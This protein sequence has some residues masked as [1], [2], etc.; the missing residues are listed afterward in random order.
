MDQLLAIEDSLVMAAL[1]GLHP[2][3]FASYSIVAVNMCFQAERIESIQHCY[4][5]WLAVFQLKV[6]ELVSIHRNRLH[7]LA[8]E[9]LAMLVVHM[10]GVVDELEP[11]VTAMVLH[12]SVEVLRMS[13]EVVR[14]SAEAHYMFVEAH[15]MIVVA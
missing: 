9:Y 3:Q 14:M 5:Q 12:M 7:G 8:F 13:A 15:H 1:E 4:V 6:L 11:D 10:L 2:E